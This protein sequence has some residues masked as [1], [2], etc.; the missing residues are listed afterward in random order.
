VQSWC[1]V[2][3]SLAVPQLAQK[4]DMWSATKHFASVEHH[5][6]AACVIRHL[7]HV[8]YLTSLHVA[9]DHCMR[10][11][12]WLCSTAACHVRLLRFWAARL[13]ITL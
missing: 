2:A 6:H 11:Q 9:G 7:F 1:R 3:R 10:C 5:S 8:K 12:P 13:P 4:C